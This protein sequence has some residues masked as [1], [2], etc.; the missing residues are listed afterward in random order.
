[1]TAFCC[2]DSFRLVIGRAQRA[3]DSEEMVVCKIRGVSCAHE[4]VPL[5]LAVV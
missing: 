4:R 2:A 5:P 3:R 1:M